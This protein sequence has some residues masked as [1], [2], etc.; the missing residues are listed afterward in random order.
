MNE[1]IKKYKNEII[2]RTQ[3]L[4]NIPSFY[5]EPNNKNPFGKSVNEALEYIESLKEKNDFWY[6]YLKGIALYELYDISFL[7]YELKEEALYYLNKAKNNIEKEN[8]YYKRI[9][10]IT[11]D[12]TE[13]GIWY[14]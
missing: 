13:Y 9:E 14:K 4:I 8:K 5:S 12:V 2:K 7:N 1:Y 3:E 10:K 6:L 11:T